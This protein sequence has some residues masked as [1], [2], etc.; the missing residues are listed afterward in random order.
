[1]IQFRL[2]M[3]AVT[4]CLGSMTVS[5]QEHILNFD[6]DRAGGPPAGWESDGSPWRVMDERQA[7]SKPH[8]LMPPETVLTGGG[9][10]HLLLS[11]SAFSSGDL[12][13]RFRM[14]REDPPSIFG[15]LWNFTDEGNYQEV[16]INTQTNTVSMATTHAGHMRSVKDEGLVFTPNTW[17]LLQIRVLAKQVIVF[18]DND[19]VLSSRVTVAK[20]SGRVGLSVNPSSPLQMD[21]F[22]WRGL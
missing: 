20:T 19:V 4:V 6:H 22:A 11:S 15:L 14:M 17:H 18:V 9:L 7:S 2:W 16:Q 3:M 10:A 21:D 12:G 1:M 5:A 13:V 8:V